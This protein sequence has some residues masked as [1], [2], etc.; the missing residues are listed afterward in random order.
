MGAK[1]EGVPPLLVGVFSAIMGLDGA[2]IGT[3]IFGA[4]W[5]ILLNTVEGARSVDGT[6]IDTARAFRLS[7][8]WVKLA[9]S[10][11]P[12]PPA[13][14]GVAADVVVPS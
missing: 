3:I 10:P 1:Q 5:P 6:K 2:P 7:K 8:A 11:A 9:V 13:S 4:V 12:G 14:V